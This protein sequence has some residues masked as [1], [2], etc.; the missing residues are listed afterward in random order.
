MRTGMKRVPIA[1]APFT[2]R[3]AGACF[4]REPTKG[5]T[6]PRPRAARPRRSRTTRTIRDQRPCDQVRKREGREAAT[7]TPFKIGYVNQ[8]SLFP[9][10]TIGVN[11]AVAYA[12]APDQQA[13]G[14]PIQ[15]VDCAGRHG[16]G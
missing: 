16:R 1:I 3:L 14:H 11:A 4:R 13:D 15:V 8:D 9:E 5:T 7:G 6:P 10:A 12:N 2:H